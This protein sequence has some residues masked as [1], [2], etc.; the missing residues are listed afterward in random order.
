MLP[1]RAPAGIPIGIHPEQ[2][3]VYRDSYRNPYA[4]I[5]SFVLK[6]EHLGLLT[7]VNYGNR[8]KSR[9]QEMR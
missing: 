8:V 6:F 1:P 9:V 4:T 5:R 3:A 7:S 2:I